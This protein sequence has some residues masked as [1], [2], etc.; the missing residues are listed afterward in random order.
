MSLILAIWSASGGLYNLD[1]AIRVAYGLPHQTYLDARAR[2][3]IGAAVAVVLL[4]VGAVAT[5]IVIAQS[6][7]VLAVIGGAVALVAI[8]GFVGALY[9]FSIVRPVA[10]RTVLP[11]AVAS[12]VGI[13]LVTVAFGTYVAVSKRFTA[14]Y[15]AFGGVVVAMLAVY[16]AVYV[17]LLGAC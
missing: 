13:V 17:V 12:A 5:S 10:L 14:V 16:F 11:G 1:R 15:G 8:A 3:F 2:A 7:F 6:S 4:G 9:R